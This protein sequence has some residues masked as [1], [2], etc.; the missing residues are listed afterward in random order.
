MSGRA[1]APGVG[2]HH[3]SLYEL[4]KHD[5]LF[6]LDQFAG[7]GNLP[8]AHL[9]RDQMTHNAT[10]DAPYFVKTGQMYLL[11]AAGIAFATS[12]DAFLVTQFQGHV[13]QAWKGIVANNVASVVHRFNA[14]KFSL[15]FR[16]LVKTEVLRRAT[17]ASAAARVSLAQAVATE[18]T[19]AAAHFA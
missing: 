9:F 4:A 3:T 11:T 8:S 19:I 6:D 13:A 14:N 16:D 17:E 1:A 12:Q 5:A 18:A 7:L 15:V 10:G 2:Y